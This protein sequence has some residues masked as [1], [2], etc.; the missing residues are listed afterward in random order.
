MNRWKSKGP[1]QATSGCKLETQRLSVRWPCQLLVPGKMGVE[2]ESSG[3]E[4]AAVVV[5]PGPGGQ[6]QGQGLSLRKPELVC[7]KGSEELELGGS[8]ALIL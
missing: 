3:E 5:E 6:G 7:Q 1:G 2:L 4:G 8:R